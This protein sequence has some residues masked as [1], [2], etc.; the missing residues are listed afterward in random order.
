MYALTIIINL[1]CIDSCIDVDSCID[2]D[3]CIARTPIFIYSYYSSIEN[4]C[5]LCVNKYI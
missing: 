2:I 3:S 5:A 4:V 1:L